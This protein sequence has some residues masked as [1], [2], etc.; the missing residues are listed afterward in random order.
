MIRVLSLP[1]SNFEPSSEK[2][3]ARLLDRGI[4][5]FEPSGLPEARRLTRWRSYWTAR[6]IASKDR[7]ELPDV[8][9]A[10]GFASA[11]L[12]IELAERWQIPYVMSADAFL[13]PGQGVRIARKRL[14]AVIVDDRELAN[15]LILGLGVPSHWVSVIPPGVE[16]ATMRAPRSESCVPVVGTAVGAGFGSGLATF[17]EAARR[18]I[19]HGL[20]AEFVLAGA[21]EE[22]TFAR[23]LAGGLGVADHLTVIESRDLDRSFWPVLDVYCHPLRW[24]SQGR[25]L[26]SAMAYG[27]PTI[28]SD[29]PSAREIS[30]DGRTSRLVVPGDAFALASSIVEFLEHSAESRE[31]GRLGRES[32]A[33]RYPA[34]DEADALASLYQRVAAGSAETKPRVRAGRA[35]SSAA[36]RLS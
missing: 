3:P 19:D 6:K 14:K 5:V 23:R 26:A 9:H 24:P 8:I 27:I 12:A 22:S 1:G 35:E 32:I 30:E 2:L 10:R 7:K 34:A 16:G 11:D 17:L 20:E 18:V 13:A 15:D 25:A 4:D 28:A 31:L 33:A 21:G 29:L 36:S